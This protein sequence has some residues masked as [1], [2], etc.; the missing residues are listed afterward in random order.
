MLTGFGLEWVEDSYGK[1]PEGAV[2]GGLT[3][4]GETLYLGRGLIYGQMTP[5]KIHPLHE[6]LYLPYAGFEY[7]LKMYEVLVTPA[8]SKVAS[9]MFE[10]REPEFRESK[11]PVSKLKKKRQEQLELVVE[12]EEIEEAEESSP[13]EKKPKMLWRKLIC[14]TKIISAIVSSL[15]SGFVIGLLTYFNSN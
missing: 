1:V 10:V 8:D 13:D 3:A 11:V 15:A 9:E 6:C 2:E 7:N 4:E 5:G 12:D 14:D